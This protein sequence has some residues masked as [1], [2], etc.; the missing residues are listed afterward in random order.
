MNRRTDR[1]IDLSLLAV[2]AVLFLLIAHR[3]HVR[4][5]ASSGQDVV[6]AAL[7]SDAEGN[8]IP[9]LDF[10]FLERVYPDEKGHPLFSR[11][12]R[13]LDG[14]TVRIHGFMTPYDSLQDMRTF[15]LFP[16]P[17]GCNFCAPPAVNQVVLV[18]QH[19]DRE[20]PRYV[21][22]PVTVTGTLRLWRE[23]SEDPAHAGDFFLYLLEDAFVR[24]RQLDPAQRRGQ[25]RG[26]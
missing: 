6:G 2:C 10:A 11:A 8:G 5:G 13:D 4:H 23:D 20:N 1:W 15:M 16:F 18:R 22:E 7:P 12:A 21:E 25:H 3:L 9:L 17:T 19:K 14:Q 24:V 26:H